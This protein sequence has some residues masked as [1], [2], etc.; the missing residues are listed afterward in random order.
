MNIG[1]IRLCLF[2]A[3]IIGLSVAVFP[4]KRNMVFLYIESGE[5][6]RANSVLHELLEKNPNDFRILMA[7]AKLAMYEGYPRRA[8]DM[9]R[10]ALKQKPRNMRALRLLALYLE[11]N[12]RPKDALDIY[13]RIVALDPDDKASL[14]KIVNFSR[15]FDRPELES[16]A[17]A[18][19][20][21]LPVPAGHHPGNTYN[22]ALKPSL[23]YLAKRRL[24]EGY[25]PLADLLMQRLYILG[26]QYTAEMREKEN[27][28]FSQFVIYALERFVISD[29]IPQGERFAERA[30][31]L[32]KSGLKNRLLMTTV[33]RWNGMPQVAVAY[34]QRLEKQYPD[35]EQILLALTQAGRDADDLRTV[36]QAFE[37][38]VATRPENPNYAS[39]LSDVYLE[40]EKYG[41]AFTMLRKLVN[42][43]QDLL[44]LLKKMIDV[45]LFSGNEDILRSAARETDRFDMND[46]ELLARRAEVYAALDE[47]GKAFPLYLRLARQEK[48]LSA[49]RNALNAGT[50]AEKAELVRQAA[51]VGHEI[52]PRDT[53]FMQR[54]ADAYLAVDRL[55]Q[56]YEEY[57]SIAHITRTEDD[58]LRM[59]ELAGFTAREKP[60]DEAVELA[61]SVRPRSAKVAAMCGEI[62]L[63]LEKPRKAYP[64]FLLAA[65]LSGGNKERVDR[66]IEVA[67]FTD[68]D[69]LFRRAVDRA[70]ALRPDD[71]ML[72]R[73]A[74]RLVL[75]QGDSGK[76]IHALNQYLKKNPQDEEARKQLAYLLLWTGKGTMGQKQMLLLSRSRRNDPAFLREWAEYTESAGLNEQAF[77]LYQRL[78]SLY[79]ANRDYRDA[80]IRLA[81]YTDRPRVAANLLAEDSDA[82]PNDFA[83]ALKTGTAMTQAGDIP[84]AV[85]YLERAHKL[86]PADMDALR[87]LARNYG[88][89]NQPKHMLAAYERIL[90]AGQSLSPE[91]NLQLAQGYVDTQQGSKAIPL[92]S[93]VLKRTPLPRDQGVLL[94]TAMLQAERFADGIA[95]YRRLAEENRTDA[96]F[97]A[98][99]GDQILFA[100][101]MTTALKFYNQA[102]KLAPDNLRALRGSGMIY[103]ETG[104]AERAIRTFRRYNRLRPDDPDIRFQLGELLYVN[105]RRGQ[106][107]REYK[108][109]LRLLRRQTATQQ[110]ANAEPE[111]VN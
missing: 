40:N 30:D 88:Y 25:E 31:R 111:A 23:E 64:Y 34:L 21:S 109:T 75:A 37:R 89:D 18:Q 38:L 96:T 19:L 80:V 49:A 54:A 61:R 101:D 24:E 43:G 9:T 71:K 62:H 72:R 50:E 6:S 44:K 52:A 57:R 29:L 56:A 17:V 70:V 73:T 69:K 106:A 68:D 47:P 39:E 53:D 108:K 1:F 94:A 51:A 67:S 63:W 20:I 28:D 98:Q 84:K 2:T 76:A 104:D 77:Q 81:G 100:N 7:G 107:H 35:N 5:V 92:L 45:A 36:E 32:S 93:D 27:P 60:I 3:V 87:E 82:H 74:L 13:E 103:A 97:L 79:P 99:V 22:K 55:E 26:R 10:H 110:Q 58:V 42:L 11:W 59:L 102:L 41:K 95:I 90:D 85:R 4:F 65:Q 83:L 16:R 12:V 105:N 91:E 78:M 15:Y 8:I 46:P 66:M 14:E 48:S 33:L 86:R